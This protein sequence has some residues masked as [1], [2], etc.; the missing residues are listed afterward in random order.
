[1]QKNLFSRWSIALTALMF[2]FALVVAVFGTEKGNDQVRYDSRWQRA[3]D[4]VG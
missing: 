4:H 2:I 3:D 1:M